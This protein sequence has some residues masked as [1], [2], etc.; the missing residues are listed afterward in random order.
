MSS[1]SIPPIPSPLYLLDQSLLPWLITT[2]NAGQIIATL[3]V[4]TPSTYPLY[5]P[6]PYV[7][8]TDTA[9]SLVWKLTII[10][11]GIYPNLLTNLQITLSSGV[12]VPSG[13]LAPS[14]NLTNYL[15]TVTNSTLT[16]TLAPFF[17]GNN[18]LGQTTISTLA[19]RVQQRLEEEGTTA[20]E[21]WS[22]QYE[23]YT[24]LVEA[25]S[26]LMLLVGRPTQSVQIPYSFTLNTPWQTMPTGVFLITNIWGPQGNIRKVDLHSMDYVMSSWGPGWES[27]SSVNGPQR[28]FPI[29]LTT[30]AVHPAPSVSQV[31]A[32]DGIAFP[33]TSTWP[34]SGSETVPFSDEFFVA[35]EEYSCSCLRLKEAGSEFQD[36]MSLYNSYLQL[37]RRM[38]EIQDRRDPLIFS[39]VLGGTAGLHSLT[40]R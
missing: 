4:T 24:A 12:N 17:P 32:I 2:G 34:Y 1:P 26:D 19:F 33:T 20:G 10:S 28:W 25:I 27:D 18:R 35:L 22:V 21:F 9:T 31:V 5:P 13:I 16:T 36:S 14:P 37:A 15:I 23:I 29:G 30:F 39:P 7:L 8:L 6:V 38:T 3:V 11:T 40:K